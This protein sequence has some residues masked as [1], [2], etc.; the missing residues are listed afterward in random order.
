MN[1]QRRMDFTGTQA[2][3]KVSTDCETTMPCRQREGGGGKLIDRRLS[4]DYNMCTVK[5]V[6]P[7]RSCSYLT[8]YKFSVVCNS[9]VLWESKFQFKIGH[10]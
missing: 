2:Q 6:E 7:A 9:V 5:Q 8:L 1:E 10:A 3:L 4:R